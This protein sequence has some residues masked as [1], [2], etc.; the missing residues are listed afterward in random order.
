MATAAIPTPIHTAV[1]EDAGALVGEYAC[2]SCPFEGVALYAAVVA[3][4]VDARAV[5]SVVVV[6]D[7]EVVGSR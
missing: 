6:V 1:S 4:A 7:M 5:V 3:A 2:M